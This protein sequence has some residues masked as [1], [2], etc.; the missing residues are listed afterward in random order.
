MQHWRLDDIHLSPS[1]YDV[2]D[3]WRT[4]ANGATT[5]AS[6]SSRPT[7]TETGPN[8]TNARKSVVRLVARED[9]AAPLNGFE[10]PDW[11]TIDLGN[12]VRVT[13]TAEVNGIADASVDAILA[14]DVLPLFFAHE[15]PA[16]LRAWRRV[17][18]DEGY[19]VVV[20]PDLQAAAEFVADDKL[21]EAIYTSGDGPVA[22][23]DLLYGP[24]ALVGLGAQHVARR[25]GFTLKVL[26]GTLQANGFATTA[27]FRRRS[28][29]ELWVIATKNPMPD[30][31]IRQLAARHFPS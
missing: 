27:G 26:S 7:L 18:K 10:G 24:R 25:C 13:T 30:D 3:R 8:T 12:P 22:P 23:L 2:A 15:I 29:F 28:T 14:H 9:V 4:A 5:V 21:T 31:A 17:L 1:F 6:L 20:C 16:A 11:Q 19:V